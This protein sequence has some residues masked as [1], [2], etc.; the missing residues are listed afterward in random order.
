MKMIS[1]RSTTA[2]SIPKGHTRNTACRCY[3]NRS[4]HRSEESIATETSI[5]SSRSQVFGTPSLTA[6]EA[7]EIVAEAEATFDSAGARAEFCSSHGVAY[8]RFKRCATIVRSLER[9]YVSECNDAAATE[10][11]APSSESASATPATSATASSA[12]TRRPE[13]YS[14]NLPAELFLESIG[15]GRGGVR[16]RV[17]I[18]G[19]SDK[20]HESLEL[21][22]RCPLCRRKGHRLRMC[23]HVPAELRPF[24]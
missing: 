22:G 3:W 17:R 19:I 11:L 23:P 9:A 1:I 8:D 5:F 20:A 6:N 12:K 15:D 13:R 16:V 10:S 24:S 21:A 2:A 14:T 18:V 7:N 4:R